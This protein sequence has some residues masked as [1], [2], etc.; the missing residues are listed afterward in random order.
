MKLKINVKDVLSTTTFSSGRLVNV[1]VSMLIFFFKVE[2]SLSK[3]LSDLTEFP[4][5]SVQLVTSLVAPSR[6]SCTFRH[7]ERLVLFFFCCD[8]HQ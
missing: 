4:L 3:I 1:A 7:R 2:D 6:Y 8:I 5:V